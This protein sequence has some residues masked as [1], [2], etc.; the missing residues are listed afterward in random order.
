MSGVGF[1]QH[2]CA[3]KQ[4]LG[5]GKW[6]EKGCFWDKFGGVWDEFGRF[7]ENTQINKGEIRLLFG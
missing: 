4:H 5:G 1:W 3:E 2:G 6:V 7:W